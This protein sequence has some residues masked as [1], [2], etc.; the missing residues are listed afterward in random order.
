MKLF[1]YEIIKR[2]NEVNEPVLP[3]EPSAISS[4]FQGFKLDAAAT[5]LSAF[6]GATELISNSVAQLPILVKRNNNVDFNHPINYLFKNGLIS[7][8]NFMK[9]LITDVIL[10]GNGYAYIERAADGTPINLVYC[11]YGSVVVN[12]NKL[13]QEIYYQ[14]PFIKKGKIE[15]IDVIHLYK[16]SNDGVN[17]IPVATYANQVLQRTPA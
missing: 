16:N 2:S 17:G 15:P 3:A 4:I 12:Y 13:K 1:G 9:M 8:F 14:I 7:K 10:H 6:F 11:E 5:S